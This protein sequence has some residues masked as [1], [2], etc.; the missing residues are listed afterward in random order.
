MKI[1]YHN[2]TVMMMMMMMMKI[3]M[4]MIIMAVTGQRLVYESMSQPYTHT[5][6]LSSLK[7][8]H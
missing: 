4:S 2:M 3:M 1:S 5:H 6:T 8:N 7:Q